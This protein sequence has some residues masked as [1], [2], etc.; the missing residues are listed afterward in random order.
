MK[1]ELLAD[2][3]LA[4]SAESELECFALDAWFKN[5]NPRNPE[6]FQ[7]ILQIVVVRDEARAAYARCRVVLHKQGKP[8]P[9]TCAECGLGPCKALVTT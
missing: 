5:Y 6:R 1:A 7:S 8:S 9:R 4:V 2:G 3:T